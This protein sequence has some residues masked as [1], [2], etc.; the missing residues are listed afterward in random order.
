MTVGGHLDTLRAS[1]PGCTLVAYGD[2]SAQL[3]LRTSTD[4]A[5]PQ[6]KLDDLCK[7]GA[8]QFGLVD[9][10]SPFRQSA[11]PTR[12]AIVTTRRDVRVYVGAPGA[13]GDVLCCVCRSGIDTDHVI[14]EARAALSNLLD[15][16][17]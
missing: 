3:V 15:R 9:A 1:L 4:S 17:Q 11:N 14:H 13:A 8:R 16:D 7:S 6:E 5:W 12:E 2:V 10:M